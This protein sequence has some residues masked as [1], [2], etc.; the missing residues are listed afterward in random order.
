ME[1]TNNNNNIILISYLNII[2]IRKK[3]EEH[4]RDIS[5]FT[6]WTNIHVLLR[7]ESQNS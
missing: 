2:I 4:K 1:C 5:I 6:N 7:S 3:L